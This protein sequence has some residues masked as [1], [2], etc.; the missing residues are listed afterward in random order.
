VQPDF[1][2]F[3]GGG[4]TLAASASGA[5]DSAAGPGDF[6]GT[7]LEQVWHDTAN[8][9]GSGDLTWI[10]T[11]TNDSTSTNSLE[12]VTASSFAGFLTDV[13]IGSGAGDHPDSVDRAT[14]GVISFNF[15]TSATDPLAGFIS[16][17][18]TSPKLF[19]E[20]NATSFT[21]GH[22]AAIDGGT[23]T[24]DAF[25][26]IVPEPST[27]VMMGLGFGLLGLA[28]IRRGRRDVISA[29]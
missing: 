18:G 24:V 25:A 5:L 15:G 8:T 7:F 11:A 9:F 21:A 23:A 27:W 22:L 29:A 12:H 14:P 28:A 16:P 1:A 4:S 20:T 13:G 19:I 17:G 10:I 6:T 26:P 3:L 2:L